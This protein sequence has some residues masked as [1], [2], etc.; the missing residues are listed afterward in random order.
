MQARLVCAA[1]MGVRVLSR[2][3]TRSAECLVPPAHAL[4][5]SVPGDLS[6]QGSGDVRPHL[7]H[8]VLAL[9]FVL[10]AL[11]VWPAL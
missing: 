9:P 4:R 2:A 6:S 8:P 5:R 1:E 3:L 7:H 11:R 10:C